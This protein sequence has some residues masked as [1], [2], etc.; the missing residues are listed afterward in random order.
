MTADTTSSNTGAEQDPEGTAAAHLFSPLTSRGVTFRNR[1]AM[2]P[3][4]QYS[5]QEGR[6]NDWHLV[7]LGS[8]AAGGV[9]LV[10]VEATAVTRD[11]R[12]SPGDMG[13]WDDQHIEPL[14][15]LRGSS[16]RR[17]RFRESSLHTP[18][19]RPVAMCPGKGGKRLKTPQEG[20]WTVV[21]PSPIP[22]A[23]GDPI[24]V[25]LMRPE[26]TPSSRPSRWRPGGP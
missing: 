11:G 7:H 1:V 22:F 14:R 21:G 8:R 6:A 23:E 10:M 16:S 18:V 20:G 2:S 9:A 4:C 26:S 12:I 13:I 5:S 24:P 25:A 19:A 3:M 15:G 17:G